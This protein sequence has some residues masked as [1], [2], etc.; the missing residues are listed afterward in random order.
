MNAT[1]SPRPRRKAP[2]DERRRQLIHAAMEAIAEKGMTGATTAEVTRRAGL[3]MG[4][5]S[6][7]FESKEGLLTETLRALAEEM[8]D[9]WADA[10]H[11]ESLPPSE[12]LRAIVRACFHPQICTPMKIAVWF[13]FFGEAPYRK[14]YRS[15]M[16]TFDTERSEAIE[17][18]CE[19][20]KVEG[21]Y[22]A[23][24]PHALATAVESLADGLWLSLLLYPNWMT[25]DAAQSQVFDMLAAHFPDHFRPGMTACAAQ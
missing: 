7:H 12:R 14:I 10:Y 4:I 1:L 5:V 24:D 18:L 21:G 22:D 3:S 16:D 13:A 17:A 25:L 19:Q 20:V 2:R 9:V 23:V 15:I 6:L 11:D 8:R